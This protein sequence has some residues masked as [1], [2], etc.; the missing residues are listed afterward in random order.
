MGRRLSCSADPCG[1]DGWS[2]PE[3]FGLAAAVV[4]LALAVLA[5]LQRKR[6][7]LTP[8]FARMTTALFA[9]ESFELLKNLTGDCVFQHLEC[10]AASLVAPTTAAV[11]ITFIGQWRALRW[12][13]IA[14][15]SYFSLLAL[16]CI[17]ATFVPVLACFSAKEPWAIAMLVG[18]V[19]EFGYLGYRLARHAATVDPTERARTQ[20]LAL[21]LV[22]GAG[23]A[24]TDLASIAASVEIKPAV[25]GLLIAAFVL[26]ALALRM[27]I[28]ATAR[29]LVIANVILVVLVVVLLQGVVW[30]ANPGSALAVTLAVAITLAALAT[31]RPILAVQSEE[32]ARLAR[33]ASLGRFSAQMAHDLKNPLAAIRGAAQ[34]LAE[35]KKRGGS[36]DDHEAF[37]HLIL[38]QT[39]RATRVVDDYQR[40]GRTEA[41]RRPLDAKALVEE[42]AQAQRAAS[43]A[44]PITTRTSG[45]LSAVPLDRDLVLGALENLVRN[46]RE[47]M[48][49]GGPIELGVEREAGWVRFWVVDAGPGMDPRHAE[50]AFDEFYTTKAT[51]SGLGLAF[52]ARV[53]EAHGGRARLVTE[54]GRG[55]T[56]R[57]ELP[58][59]ER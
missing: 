43:A 55:T 48:E 31:L 18:M 35:E 7:P 45:E 20:L 15:A 25:F 50:R 49:A 59:V 26:A 32:R 33:L 44:H 58:I 51:G 46:A 17:L 4:Y 9:Y 36:I 28:V 52:V 24:G 1:A 42:L 22:L 38:E 12:L 29:S 40:L 39:D 3:W 13:V 14:G 57:M 30:L 2:T 16:L 34:F 11:I 5:V 10:A 21:A 19:P 23:S 37:I 56:V 6:D 41:V 53:A 54:L 47:A 27:E 8:P